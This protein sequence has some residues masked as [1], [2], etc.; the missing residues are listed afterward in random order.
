MIT[1]HAG[2]EQSVTD[3][4]SI[5]S[6]ISEINKF[7]EK[8]AVPEATN[9]R[10]NTTNTR[11]FKLLFWMLVVVFPVIFISLSLFATETWF[12]FSVLGFL[13][14]LVITPIIIFLVWW[15]TIK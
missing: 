14:N 5:A 12:A 4:Q 11:S 6:Q 1:N 10:S 15:K 3:S 2:V 9:T 7:L 8:H 13:A